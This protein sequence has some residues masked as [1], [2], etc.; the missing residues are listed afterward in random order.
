[1]SS[2]D[3]AKKRK[4]KGDDGSGG[5]GGIVPS[6]APSTDGFGGTANAVADSNGRVVD[7]SSKS[8]VAVAVA[9]ALNRPLPRIRKAKVYSSFGGGGLDGAGGRE[10]GH[11]NVD[12]APGQITEGQVLPADRGERHDGYRWV[13]PL[14]IRIEEI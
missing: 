5:G 14:F 11:V 8:N 10:G 13:G 3:D 7:G 12:G 4:R 2:G 9:L 6:P 1:M